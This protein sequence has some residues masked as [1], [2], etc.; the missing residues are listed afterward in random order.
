MQVNPAAMWA[1]E[2]HQLRWN[3][4]TALQGGANGVAQAL[5]ACPSAPAEASDFASQ[6]LKGGIVASVRCPAGTSATL[7]GLQLRSGATSQAMHTSPCT[8]RFEAI[9]HPA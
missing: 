6:G 3:I 1:S 4:S 2:Q 7:S 5:F 9:A 8:F